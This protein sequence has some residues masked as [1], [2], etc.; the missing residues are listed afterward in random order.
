MEFLLEAIGEMILEVYMHLMSI[1]IPEKSCK[2]KKTLAFMATI[3]ASLCSIALL[4]CGICFVISEKPFSG[5]LLIFLAVIISV[6]HIGAGLIL[7][8][9][10]DETDSGEYPSSDEIMGDDEKR[11]LEIEN[12][13]DRFAEKV[14]EDKIMEYTPF[15]EA[16]IYEISLEKDKQEPKD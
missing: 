10:D 5:V 6:I 3:F 1:V 7:Q 9:K 11:I 13:E 16:N 2:T 14:T 15:D 12:D 8:K 4:I